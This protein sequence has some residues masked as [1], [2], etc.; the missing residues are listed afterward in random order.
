M[1]NFQTLTGVAGPEGLVDEDGTPSEPQTVS[2]TDNVAL[3]RMA[4]SSYTF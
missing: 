3:P 4:R 1:S 2:R